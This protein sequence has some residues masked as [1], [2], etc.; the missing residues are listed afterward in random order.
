MEGGAA[1]AVRRRPRVEARGDQLAQPFELPRTRRRQS[2]R[3]FLL[4]FG[5]VLSSASGPLGSVWTVSEQ[6]CSLSFRC[7]FRG[8]GRFTRRSSAVYQLT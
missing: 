8:S 7:I 5:P 3:A 1:V 2:F 6:R 4:L